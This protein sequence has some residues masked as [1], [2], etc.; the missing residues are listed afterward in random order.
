LIQEKWYRGLTDAFIQHSLNFVFGGFGI[1]ILALIV[2]TIEFYQTGQVS[3]GN[4]LIF[5]GLGTLSIGIACLSLKIAKESKGIAE[6]SDKKMKDIA[7]SVYKEIEGI[8][9]DRRLS[10]MKTR[11][12]ITRKKRKGM[13]TQIDELAFEQ[14]IIFGIW[15]CLTYLRR[16][17]VLIKY[18]DKKEQKMIIGLLE[19][20]YKE[21]KGDIMHFG[22]EIPDEYCKQ[23]KKMHAIVSKF[24]AYPKRYD[25]RHIPGA[26]QFL[27]QVLTTNEELKEKLK[28]KK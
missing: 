19:K 20:F 24:D 3:T 12:I 16:I 13:D 4:N 25:K 21:L 11:G 17:R 1:I 9:E 18:I 2:G 10:I 6:N 22:I 26:K 8:F 23:L 28:K 14:D 15:K 7:L 27:E 5:L